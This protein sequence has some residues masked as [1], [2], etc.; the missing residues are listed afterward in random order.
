MDKL[1]AFTI[2]MFGVPLI[3]VM[4]FRSLNVDFVLQFVLGGFLF[5]L[6]LAIDIWELKLWVHNRV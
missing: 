2:V 6:G 5:A 4:D 1:D 3:G